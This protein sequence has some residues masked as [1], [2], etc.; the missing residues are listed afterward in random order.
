MYRRWNLLYYEHYAEV[1]KITKHSIK[2]LNVGAGT[3]TLNVITLNTGH[4]CIP[5]DAAG[6]VCLSLTCLSS[7]SI[8]A[9]RQVQFIWEA[10][11]VIHVAT[12][13]LVRLLELVIIIIGIMYHGG[14]VLL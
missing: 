1:N 4:P 6:D 11:V 9:C 7:A 10:N 2:I 13:W 12:Q 3:L 14:F 5:G 8:V